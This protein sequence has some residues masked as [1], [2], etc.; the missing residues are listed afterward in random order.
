M[1]RKTLAQHADDSVRWTGIPALV[2]RP[3][4]RRPRRW[5]PVLAI[6]L[7][8]AG[9]VL[10]LADPARSWR[11]TPLIFAAIAIGAVVRARGPLAFAG[12]DRPDERERALYYR[13]YGSTGFVIGVV[14]PLALIGLAAHANAANWTRDDLSHALMAASFF[15]MALWSALPTLHASWSMP[16]L[17][18]DD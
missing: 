11:G 14:G 18:D 1:P 2:T 16:S 6:V 12:P 15:T 10:T 4:S 9:L 8:C 17:P 3:P 5:W 13:A 7:A